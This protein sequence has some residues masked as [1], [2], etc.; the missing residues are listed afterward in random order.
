MNNLNKRIDLLKSGKTLV[1][2]HHG[3]GKFSFCMNPQQ[4]VIF[5]HAID[6]I[7]KHHE[8]Q[9]IVK[10]TD[11][12]I[13]HTSMSVEHNPEKYIFWGYGLWQIEIEP[14]QEKTVVV[15]TDGVYVDIDKSHINFIPCTCYTEQD[16]KFCRNKGKCSKIEAQ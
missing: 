12:T 4:N 15:R 2:T 10:H 11:L 1:M 7:A 3:Y 16:K 13:H 6:D 14:P 8:E 9:C 5:A